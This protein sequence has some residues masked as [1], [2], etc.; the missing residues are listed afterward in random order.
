MVKHFKT[1]LIAGISAIIGLV[2]CTTETDF[3]DRLN[4]LEERVSKLE[5]LCAEMNTNISSLQGIV[6]ALQNQDYITAVN[7]LT[8]DGQV[9]GYTINFAKGQ[10]ITIYH[11]KDGVNGKDGSTPVIGVKQDTDGIWYWTLNGEWLLDDNGQKIKAVGTDG[12][13]GQNGKDGQ[14]GKDGQNGQD[15][16]PGKDGI[17]PQLKIEEGYW[18]VST[19]NGQTWVQLGKATGE[20]GKD[21]VD[22]K[23]GKD[24]VD[25]VDGDSMFQNVTVTETEV[26]FVTSDGQTFVVK[27]AAALSIEF[28]SADLVVM[29]TNST[30]NIHYTITSGV[31]NITIE[32]LSSADIKVKVVK[33]DAK[34]GTLQVKIGATIDE[35]S[36]VVVL[37][38]N[39]SQAIMR[40]LNFEE[41]AIEVEEN[42]T[43]EVTDKGGEVTLEF[44]SNT[45]CHV[46]I[47]DEAQSWISVAPETKALDR[48]TIGLI[49][50][51]NNGAARSATVVVKS[52]DG[53]LVLTFT[54]EQA[55]FNK[56]YNS[57]AYLNM[58]FMLPEN[59]DKTI[60]TSAYFHV[61]SEQQTE[62]ILT[63]EQDCSPVYFEL[64]GT[65]A[66]YYTDAEIYEASGEISFAG[67]RSLKTIDLSNIDTRN[68][69][70]FFGLFDG[71][72]SLESLDLSGFDTS[73]V[74]TMR[75]MFGGCQSL[76]SINFSGFN[77][78]KVTD[79]MCMF[80][81][82]MLGHSANSD[83]PGCMSLESLDLTMF[84][85]S[86]VTDMTM[87]F[88]RCYNLKELILSGWNT[89]NVKSM[90]RMFEGC[91]S[92][93]N[94][95]L[96]S[97]NTE[98][99]ANMG[100][101]FIACMNLEAI[102]L[103]AFNT[104]KV[105][106]MT[107]LFNSCYA[108]REI[109]LSGFSYESLY[110]DGLYG[111][112]DRC[113]HL[114]KID[115]GDVPLPH[116]TR[117]Y[118]SF[119]ETSRNSRACAIRCTQENKEVILN[120]ANQDDNNP[121]SYSAI[122]LNYF[123]WVLPGEPIPD[124]PDEIDPNLYRSTDYS[125]DG[126]IVILQEAT[127]G[128]GIDI[129]LVGDAYSDRLIKDGT[130]QNDMEE[131]VEAI[132]SLEP[133]RT[134]RNLFNVYMVVAVSPNEVSSGET[135][136]NFRTCLVPGCESDVYNYTRNVVR[137]KYSAD[138][139]TVVISHDENCLEG[140]G[141]DGKTVL[142]WSFGSN[143]EPLDFGQAREAIAFIPRFSDTAHFR[144]V[145][146]HEFGHCFAKLADEYVVVDE[147]VPE[148]IL[149]AYY[150]GEYV[151]IT[152]LGIFRNI[153]FISDPSSIKWSRFLNDPRYD[154]TD[155][156]VF[157]GG[158]EYGRG[159]WRPSSVSIMAG[160]GEHFNA[161]SREAIYNRI[162]KLAYGYDWVY[163]YEFFV[164]YDMEN[165]AAE[166]VSI[167]SAPCMF[168]KQRKM[169]SNLHRPSTKIER[170]I[171]ANGDK[172]ITII[173][174]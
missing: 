154:G 173:M 67:W 76:K 31:D 115:F 131:A 49:V 23:D 61:L 92:L 44:F 110:E 96:S 137:D 8:S 84:D 4:N 103:S 78:K 19:D 155:T 47:P 150:S 166:K 151:T 57:R 113:R 11:G 98:S 93:R 122:N 90:S 171:A 141:A 10:P 95:D 174:E 164:E 40:T 7:E 130:Y 37:V 107:N 25:G 29:G 51:P 46:E 119:F 54:I 112:F 65:E 125:D 145:V 148:W 152:K 55:R 101:M 38:S 58:E 160:S 77:T 121:W 18:Y 9:I 32:A 83:G 5:K 147:T 82:S 64:I 16:A 39:G 106:E 87:M 21:G 88:S 108:L 30:R 165:I 45:P 81:P 50:Q 63:Q 52:E 111:I 73:N 91:Y 72:I 172:T 89:S 143:D 62:L 60:I 161:P 170:S 85:T 97:F 66:H 117:L 167:S 35:Y 34:T 24:G 74:T 20:N 168:P 68:V 109:N 13:D 43:K 132:F 142:S 102:D 138:I 71:C 12:K 116:N 157:E 127:A 140:S 94:L 15:G 134:F 36:K 128:R 70:S 99:L 162:H 75:F 126:K 129:I 86:N 56:T 3:N 80:G 28:D 69:T 156:G 120:S 41:E 118:W 158:F 144:Y 133:Y 123:T 153:D 169:Q 124:L 114:K 105:E 79:M 146:S 42:T 17:T 139:A 14:D 2:S 135:A 27:R 22:G 100:S 104:S 1:I 53:S 26:T 59:V 6:S 48:Q 159:V 163:D 33:T 136:L 149:D